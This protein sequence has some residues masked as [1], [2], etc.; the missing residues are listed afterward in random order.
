M[1][2]LFETWG[3]QDMATLS[4]IIVEIFSQPFQTIVVLP[5]VFG[6]N[7]LRYIMASTKLG[8]KLII[9]WYANQILQWPYNSPTK[10]LVHDIHIILLSNS[11]KILLSNNE[12]SLLHMYSMKEFKHRLVSEIWLCSWRFLLCLEQLPLSICFFGLDWFARS[13]SS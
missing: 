7:C 9:M 2:H 10:A 12:A 4:E 8:R 3:C 11:F 13:C 5:P 6:R 1:A